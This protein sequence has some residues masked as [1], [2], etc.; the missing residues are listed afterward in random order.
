MKLLERLNKGLEQEDTDNYSVYTGMGGISYLNLHLHEIW[1]DKRYLETGL[2]CLKHHLRHLKGR[3]LSFLC[4]DTGPLALGAVIYQKLGNEAAS[5]DCIRRLEELC[6]LVCDDPSLPDE[7]LFGRVGYIYALM[8]VQH[9]LGEGKLNHALIV[10]VAQCVI[11]SGQR[12]ARHQKWKHP[13]MYAWHDKHYLGA[14]HGLAGIFYI[15][16]MIKDDVIKQQ[17]HELV[18]PS[19]DYLLTLRFPSGNCPSSIGSS[20]GDKLIHWCHGAPG[21][22]H[23]FIQAYKVFGDGK[24]LDAAR[25]CA[26]VIWQRGLLKK[27]YGVCHGVA[28]NGYAFLAMYQLTKE[29]KYFYRAYKFGEW[30]FDYGAHGCRRPDSPLSLFEGLAGTIYFLTDL[31]DPMAA[32]FPAFQLHSYG[33]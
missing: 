28:G 12:L 8:F 31:M 24:Y 2:D 16:M 13:L 33:E 11:D 19:I 30:C 22:I 4:G 25:D 6:P 29:E 17:V 26:E 1:N 20:A 27:G 23:M 21:W 9:N 15:L 7:L 10:K 14:A 5:K 18:K 3:K 32:R